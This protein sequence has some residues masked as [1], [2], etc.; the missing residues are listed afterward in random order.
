MIARFI[1]QRDAEGGAMAMYYHIK[2]GMLDLQ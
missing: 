2:R 1:Q